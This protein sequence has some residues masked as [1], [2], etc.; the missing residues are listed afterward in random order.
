MREVFVTLVEKMN[1]ALNEALEGT[2]ETRTTKR[3]APDEG[4]KGAEKQTKHMNTA[5]PSNGHV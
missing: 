1:T 3:K 5:A 2:A 4:R